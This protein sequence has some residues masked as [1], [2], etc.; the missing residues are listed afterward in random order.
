[1]GGCLGVGALEEE[2][3]AFLL[4]PT[5]GGEPF[6]LCYRCSQAFSPDGRYLFVGTRVMLEEATSSIAIPLAGG[7][8]RALGPQ[9]VDSP[10]G[11][12]SL[13]GAKVVAHGASAPGNDLDTYAFLKM[14]AHRNLYRIP[15]R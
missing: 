14:S 13:P 3:S 6:R 15:L 12:R 5:G 11:L 8:P 4:Y 1:M 2:S 9:G 10:V 7:L